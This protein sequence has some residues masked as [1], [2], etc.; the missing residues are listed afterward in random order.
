MANKYV[1]LIIVA[2]SITVASLSIAEV[3]VIDYDEIGATANITL[4]QGR[5]NNDVLIYAEKLVMEFRWL[6]SI[7]TDVVYPPK[8]A[9]KK[10]T[11]T[12]V[13]VVDNNSGSTVKHTAGG[14]GVG[15]VGFRFQSSW[16]GPLNY[17]IKIYGYVCH[18]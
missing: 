5:Q 12:Y 7:V 1:S 6:R 16:N 8:K 17:D 18:Q 14:I 11:I 2:V 13:E 9:L 10:I 15:F 3:G 4:G